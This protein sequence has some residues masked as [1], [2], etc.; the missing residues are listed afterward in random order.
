MPLSRVPT[1]Q[2]T[3]DLSFRNRIINGDMRIDQR[4]NGASITLSGAE[5]RYPVD[6]FNGFNDTDGT[7][8]AQQVAEAPAG[9]VN[10][11][12]LTVTTADASIGATQRTTFRQRIEGLNVSDL[13][14]G[15][16][17]A[18]A[19]TLSF[20][21]KSSVT[22]THGGSIMNS[23]ADYSYPFT[24]AISVANTWEFKTITIAGP[25]AGTWL[26]TNGIGL[27]VIYG[28]AMGSTYSGTA[29]SW[30]AT[31]YEGA[32]GA[33]QVT[34]TLNATWYITGVELEKGST[35]TSFDYRPYG[36]ELALCQRYFRTNGRLQGIWTTAQ[37]IRVIE[38]FPVEMRASP[39]LGLIDTNGYHEYWNT[40]G[41]N[42]L[43]GFGFT[44]GSSKS[45]DMVLI[46]SASRGRSFNDP[47]MLEGNVVSYNAEL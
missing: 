34:S 23:S 36:T 12:K 5:A 16:A 25:T 42:G 32:T 33:V 2:L 31:R 21:V 20:W 24:Y 28:L 29:G 41:Y 6:R 26:T 9:F 18:Q 19:V 14:W 37:N 11:S 17:S 47:A 44:Q 3:G 35:A 7:V 43:S 30:S 39:T 22:G 13:G 1:A 4:N 40:A 10:S 15:T 45:M 8:T 38:T 27:Q 46:A